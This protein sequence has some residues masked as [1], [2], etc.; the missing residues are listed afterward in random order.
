MTSN[1]SFLVNQWQSLAQAAMEA[2]RNVYRAPLYTAILCRKSLEEW[3]RWI[4]E[5]DEELEFPYD[6]TLN[7]L[8]F[9]EP[10]KQLIESNLFNQI[11]LVR[12][13]GNQAVHVSSKVSPQE[14]LYSLR[15]LHGFITWVVSLYSETKPEIKTFDESLVP[16]EQLQEKS[17][18]DLLE[19]EK[20]YL[21]T[22]ELV[23]KLQK[24][25]DAVKAYKE[26]N[27]Q[28]VSP[29]VD[30]TEDLTR[31]LY[32]N[33]LLKEAGWDPAG[34]NVPEFRVTGMPRVDGSTGEGFVDYVLW[35]DN[36]KPLAVVEA[37][38]TMRDSKVGQQ[39]AKLYAD[40]LGK[41]Y[42]QRP[43]IYYSNG[44]YTWFW[45]D[46]N[47]PPRGIYGF[48]TKDELQAIINRRNS[49]KDLRK[50]TINLTITDRYYQLEAI[51]ACSE[52][53][54]KGTREALLVMATGTGKTRT[55]AALIDLLNK[56]GWN[57][58]TLFLADRNALVRQAKNAFNNYLPHLPAIDLTKE[59][60]DDSSRVV[61]ST[62][63]TL[64]NMID[65][66]FHG[67]ERFYGIGH[68]D[69][70]IFD[71]IHRTVYNKYKVIFKYF[72]ALKIGLTATPASQD[73]RDT[74]ELFGLE[75]H[76][77]TYAYELERAMND[78]YLVPFQTSPLTT[79]FQR[80]GIKYAE[81]SDEE[82]RKYEEEFADPIT[83][84]FPDEIDATALNEWLFNIDT[85]DK[86]IGCLM[87]NGIKVNGG[88]TLGKTIIFARS[89]KHAQFIEQR[90]NIQYP[91]HKG[92]FLRVIDNYEEYAYDLLM[93]FSNQDEMPQIAVSVD[94]LD[95]GIDIPEIVNLVFFK[96]IRSA[97]KFWQ[98]IGRG[99]RLS[100]NLFAPGVD[101]SKF[102]IFDFCGNFEFFGMTPQG[103]ELKDTKSLTQRI[104]ETRLKLAVL[105]KAEED[106]DLQLYSAE[107]VNLLIN[108]TAALN[109]ESFIVRQQWRLVEK[110]KDP[111][112]WNSLTDHDIR[113]I[114][115][116]IAPLIEP[117]DPDE[118][119]KRFD[120][121]ML[122]LQLY[123]VL[124]DKRQTNLIKQVKGIGARLT[125]KSA[126]PL[127]AQKMETLLEIQTNDFWKEITLPAVEKLR[128]EIRELIKFLEKES[129]P[130]VYTDFEDEFEGPW[131]SQE[132]TD[133]A[134]GD[135]SSYKRRVEKFLRDN[136]NHLTIQ[137]LK[138]NL[139][140]TKHELEELEQMLF[141]QGS[142]GSKKEL[143]NAYGDQ[144]LG[145]FIRSILG[146]D[147]SAAKTAFSGF[148]Q[149]ST[150]NSQQ[151]RF[152]D[153]I[154]NF[155]TVNGNID[156]GMLFESPF[157]DI[158]SNG[159]T[160]VFD[161]N[162]AQRII[163][164]INEINENAVAA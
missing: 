3:V 21:D 55:A 115:R 86:V 51:K 50:E 20:S 101:K 107:L 10:F 149:S 14:A 116:Y 100:K 22:Q 32:I 164:T 67:E 161:I 12:K 103:I 136:Q 1:F 163:Q 106:Q 7:S 60:E 24:E 94:M 16:K 117:T 104:F 17:R 158:S 125:K 95:T 33:I 58:R 47:Y 110:Y 76:N 64:I 72:D 124:S 140:I 97:I 43:L 155:L 129:R 122:N 138:T 56:A 162:A 96:P 87:E 108:Q 150:F 90:F 142:I 83:G 154:I 15:L 42:S 74:Y 28:Y 4:Y 63:Q 126:I 71:E 84:E 141:S 131:V 36:G 8:I 80:Q 41:E 130:I 5:H 59:K 65:G 81:L 53:F 49:K 66:E 113:D 146:L 26:R 31:K 93:K 128:I 88:D 137:K 57:K 48:H 147:I 9:N 89:H 105:L 109:Q 68:F 44:F 75:P 11:N 143:V 121:L 13:I 112:A 38:R 6:T 153:T 35:S 132:V 152:I 34:P 98:M 85:V 127:V 92:H 19:L 23:R 61:F 18:M 27:S 73:T 52:G 79:K 54:E 119:A 29:P 39:Q 118:L 111:G 40:C 30:P 25:L 151:I 45:D 139:P 70:V 133:L 123:Q 114:N 2:E 157:T 77:P 145:I 156:P 46:L 102:L 37:K 135:L 78:K 160:G 99:T 159:L 91:Q 62:Y 82:K 134:Y 148:L 144:P 120:L 69:T